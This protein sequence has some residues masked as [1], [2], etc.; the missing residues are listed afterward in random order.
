MATSP[1][2]HS[3]SPVVVPGPTHS[4]SSSAQDELGSAGHEQVVLC[5]DRN[6]V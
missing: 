1:V 6:L 5:H 3:R 4:V 2:R